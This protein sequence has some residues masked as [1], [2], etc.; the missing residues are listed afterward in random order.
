MKFCTNCGAALDGEKFC[1]NCGAPTGAANDEREA[2]RSEPKK[3]TQPNR[4]SIGMLVFSIINM[5]TGA[6]T[7]G[8]IS[9]VLTLLSAETADGSRSVKYMKIAK[10]LNIIGVVVTV[11]TVVAIVV[12]TV[13]MVIAGSLWG[14]FVMSAMG[15]A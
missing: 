9:L 12:Y 10:I 6:K 8:I 7:L 4:L 11:L 1:T 3:N 14:L 13:L 15:M 5:V 2:K